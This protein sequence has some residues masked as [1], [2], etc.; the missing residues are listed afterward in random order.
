MA[1]VPIQKSTQPNK[2][3]ILQARKQHMRI[4][5]MNQSSGRGSPRKQGVLTP[6]CLGEWLTGLIFAPKTPVTAAKS[7]PKT[8]EL[9]VTLQ[10]TSGSLDTWLGAGDL[11]C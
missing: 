2:L 10:R 9:V 1:Q 7:S 5:Y 4:W 3:G 11:C 8:P 6:L